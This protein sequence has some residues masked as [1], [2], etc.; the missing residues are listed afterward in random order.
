MVTA[1]N[2]LIVTGNKLVRWSLKEIL[3]QEGFLADIALTTKDSLGKKAKNSY[4]LIIVDD[5][6][7]KIDNI[8]IWE[9]IGEL[10]P[11]TN[12]VILSSLVDKQPEAFLNRPNIFSVIAKPFSVDQIKDAALTALSSSRTNDGRGK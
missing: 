10:F 2:I 1:A 5:E 6:A 11:S 8:D 9:K 7:P 12:I 4:S 3:T